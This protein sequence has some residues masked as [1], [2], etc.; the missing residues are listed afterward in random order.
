MPVCVGHPEPADG[1]PLEVEFDQHRGL[2]SNDLPVVPRLDN[3]DLR[4]G[5]LRGTSVRV[6]DMYLAAGE[7]TDVSVHA[8]VR[9]G[10]SLHVSRPAKSGRVDYSLNTTGAGPRNI[11]L[12]VADYAAFAA[13]KGCEQWIV[14][15]MYPS[16]VKSGFSLFRCGCILP[17]PSCTGK[18]AAAIELIVRTGSCTVQ[19][20][21]VYY[22]GR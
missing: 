17:I 19:R 8:E 13:L 18:L 2:V 21:K 22:D 5:E 12:G 14:V 3:D 15:L 1:V 4:S 16:T 11:D 6:L 9:A 7:E 10:D 20:F